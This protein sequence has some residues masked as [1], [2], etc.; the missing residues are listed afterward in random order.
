MQYYKLQIPQNI[1]IGK[2]VSTHLP[3]FLELQKI[4]DPP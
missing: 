1:N 3:Y 2:K 4:Y